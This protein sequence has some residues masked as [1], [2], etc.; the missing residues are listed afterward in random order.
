M[1]C[2]TDFGSKAVQAAE[3]LSIYKAI[4]NSP[5][6]GTQLALDTCW[7]TNELG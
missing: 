4:E 3:T 6:G 7:K 5:M 1:F 2:C